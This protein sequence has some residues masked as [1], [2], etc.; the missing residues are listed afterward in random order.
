MRKLSILVF[1]AALFP[2]QA[3]FAQE[4]KDPHGFGVDFDTYQ[5]ETTGFR[6][7]L[8]YHFTPERALLLG[9]G[10]ET[11]DYQSANGKL[12]Q[13][14]NHEFLL[15]WSATTKVAADFYSDLRFI[16]GHAVIENHAGPTGE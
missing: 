1:V 4:S 11:Y 5:T 12:K 6:G 10:A 2:A 3:L 8:S 16:V 15:G 9:L 14:P 13:V 7:Q